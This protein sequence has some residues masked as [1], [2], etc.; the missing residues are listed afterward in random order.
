MSGLYATFKFRKLLG[1]TLYTVIGIITG[2]RNVSGLRQPEL[3]CSTKKQENSFNTY[4]IEHCT[5][6]G[7]LK[8]LLLQGWTF[9]YFLSVLFV[10][11]VSTFQLQAGI[12]TQLYQYI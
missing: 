10:F 9:Q 5:V 12:T 6:I 3:N 1:R 11:T 2:I 8:F 7:G 4:I